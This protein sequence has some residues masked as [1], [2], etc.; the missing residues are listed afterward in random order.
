[1]CR[2]KGI[3]MNKPKCQEDQGRG[4]QV[5]PGEDVLLRGVACEHEPEPEPEPPQEVA[6]PV[7]ASPYDHDIIFAKG[8]VSDYEWYS[9][10]L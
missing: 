6:P 7:P 3:G 8:M 2:H 1:M 9:R 5:L 4:G 10:R